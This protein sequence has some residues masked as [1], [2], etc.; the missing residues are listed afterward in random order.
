MRESGEGEGVAR[1]NE[2]GEQ[3]EEKR[4]AVITGAT[5]GIGR[6]FAR[7]FAARGYDLI[8][9]GR[10]EKQVRAVAEEFTM[11]FGT[12][13]EVVIADFSN[14]HELGRLEEKIRSTVNL[15]VL[16]NNAGFGSR[17]RFFEEHVSLQASMVEVHDTAAVRLTHAAVP[18]MLRRG[19]GIIINVSSVAAWLV[20]PRSSVYAA[21]KVFLNT[22]TEGL[23]MEL[24]PKGIRVQAL[25]P[26]FTK[27]DFHDR[28]GWDEKKKRD[29][30]VVRWMSAEEVVAVSLGCLERG[31]VI[32][33]PGFWNRLVVFVMNLLP[34][35]LYYRIAVRVRE[36][37]REEK[38]KSHE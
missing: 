11:G 8:I 36:R 21:S 3:V 14:P 5:S 9:T 22:F 4:T 31:K 1:A 10:R 15:E 27:T 35:S 24:R 25:C 34:R 23:H 19:V 17:G 32:C 26:G 6:A 20:L 7:R 29:R 30:R 2:E 13:V 37:E 38:G 33:I 16:V 18:E 28:L 12:K